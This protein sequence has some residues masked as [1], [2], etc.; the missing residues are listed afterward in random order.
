MDSKDNN[1]YQEPQ[2]PQPDNQP[3]QNQYYNQSTPYGTQNEPPMTLGD[4]IIT[5]LIMAIPCVNIIMIFVWAFGSGVNT[6]KKNYFRAM[7]I[8]SAIGIVISLLFTSLVVGLF[9]S[10]LPIF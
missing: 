2:Q 3:Q 7:L 10:L 8:F 9:R 4:W 1:N 6:S 5:L